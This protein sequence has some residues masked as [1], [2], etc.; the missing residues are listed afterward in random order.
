[1][2]LAALKAAGKKGTCPL[3]LGGQSCCVENHA[4]FWFPRSA[5][6]PPFGRSASRNGSCPRRCHPGTQSVRDVGSRAERGNQGLLQS[7]TVPFFCRGN[8]SC[9]LQS[10]AGLFV[11]GFQVKRH[12]HGFRQPD[13][14]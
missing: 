4:A 1:M 12:H 9:D 7:R 2:P 10:A 13:V 3:D 5:W 6:E 14:P 8:D 11:S